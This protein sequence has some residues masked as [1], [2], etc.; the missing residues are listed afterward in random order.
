[1]DKA[2]E[3]KDKLVLGAFFAVLLPNTLINGHTGAGIQIHP[4]PDPCLVLKI[5]LGGNHGA[6][7]PQRERGGKYSRIPSLSHR[8]DSIV[9][10]PE[11]ALT[12]PAMAT[13]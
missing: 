7:S 3:A 13:V 4:R 11:L 2:P 10:R 8:W 9:R 12:P 5:P 1:M 6:L